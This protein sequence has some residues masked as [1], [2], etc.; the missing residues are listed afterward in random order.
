MAD[1]VTRPE[2]RARFD[3]TAKA[4]LRAS[5][6]DESA[7]SSKVEPEKRTASIP[8]VPACASRRRPAPLAT[9]PPAAVHPER[10]HTSETKR[11]TTSDS[12]DARIERSISWQHWKSSRSEKPESATSNTT[13]WRCAG[14]GVVV[15]G[16][17]S[18]A[19][20]VATGG[21][22]ADV[23]GA[24]SSVGGGGVEEVVSGRAGEVVGVGAAVVV[25]GG[26]GA[27]EEDV[28]GGTAHSS[29]SLS[30]PAVLA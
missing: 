3:E 9:A 15:T 29:T 10:S 4:R 19:T 20:V 17:S 1:T 16:G 18:R 26:G 14:A 23:R 30:P 28:G 7:A 5:S 27:E 13:A 6:V 22:G 21:C 2:A 8:A 11:D 24:A 12:S 25:G